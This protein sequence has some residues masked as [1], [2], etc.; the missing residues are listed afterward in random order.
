MCAVHLQQ[1]QQRYATCASQQRTD[2]AYRD[3]VVEISALTGARF[4]VFALS[5]ALHYRV[6]RNHAKAKIIH[7]PLCFSAAFQRVR[8]T[9][10]LGSELCYY[11]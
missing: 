4:H 3:L 9:T 6:H 1:R 10:I 11:K 8:T 7:R 5:H 2:D